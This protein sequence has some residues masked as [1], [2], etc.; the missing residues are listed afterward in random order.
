MTAEIRVVGDRL[1][2]YTDD[3]QVYRRFRTRIVPLRKVR[4]FQRGR[5]IG[6]DLYFDKKQKKVV[7]AIMKGQLALDI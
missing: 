1:A 6:I 2:L 3:E 4:Y 7:T 5:V